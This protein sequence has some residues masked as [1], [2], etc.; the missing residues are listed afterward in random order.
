M[1][2]NVNTVQQQYKEKCDRVSKKV[3]YQ[4]LLTTLTRKLKKFSNSHDFFNYLR[5]LIIEIDAYQP[6]IEKLIA[7]YRSN[8]ED[9]EEQILTKM[10]ARTIH[11]IL[12]GQFH[13]E[14][15]DLNQL[16]T[17]GEAEKAVVEK[18]KLVRILS[19]F[20]NK[21]AFVEERINTVYILRNDLPAGIFHLTR[22]QC[23]KKLD[24]YKLMDQFTEG[25]KSLVNIFEVYKTPILHY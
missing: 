24:K 12:C 10:G 19:L 3:F 14:D 13:S 25:L 7:F 17:G 6:R 16:Q 18:R 5:N 20:V 2:V 4:E 15:L 23:Q 9:Q 21:L 22:L 1:K 11:S 8:N